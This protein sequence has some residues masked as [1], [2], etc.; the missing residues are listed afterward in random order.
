MSMRRTLVRRGMICFTAVMLSLAM[1]A[2]A[3]AAPQ[4]GGKGQAS[5]T[6]GENQEEQQQAERE[7]Q[8][9]AREAEQDRMDRMQ[10]LYDQGREALDEDQFREAERSFS[11]LTK[12]G[13]PQTDAALYWTAYAQN[14]EGKKD[15]AIATIAETTPLAKIPSTI[16][17]VGRS[18]SSEVK[19]MKAAIIRRHRRL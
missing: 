4:G 13:G 14:R 5:E 2:G 11:E 6:L 9:Q 8:A 7:R 19:M 18:A 1:R 12:L 15:A 10:E 16:I 17:S 3:L